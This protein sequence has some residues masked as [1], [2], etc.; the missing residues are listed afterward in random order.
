MWIQ[1]FPKDNYTTD[2]KRTGM[3]QESIHTFPKQSLTFQT[4]SELRMSGKGP[5]PR[6]QPQQWLIH[7]FK[8]S[9]IG[10]SSGQTAKRQNS[11]E[12]QPCKKNQMMINSC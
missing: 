5:R 11:A 12:R 9:L 2:Q 4:S 1:L 3:L 6:A 7:V 10:S 8:W